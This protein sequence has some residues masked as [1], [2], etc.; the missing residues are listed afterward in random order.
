MK[1]SRK[2]LV[3][4]AASL[5][6]GDKS[7]RAILAGLKKS[8]LSKRANVGVFMIDSS[9]LDDVDDFIWAIKSNRGAKAYIK[10]SRSEAIILDKQVSVEEAL[11]AYFEGEGY[12]A[13]S[14]EMLRENVDDYGWDDFDRLK[15][16]RM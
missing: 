15:V 16:E 5:P 13:S 4:L 14:V 8:S 1:K 7:R 2:S 9:S 10:V 3:R 11:R 6:K 12:D